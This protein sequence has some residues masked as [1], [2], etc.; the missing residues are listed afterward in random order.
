MK[1]GERIQKIWGEP[2]NTPVFKSDLITGAGRVLVEVK[3]EKYHD[4]DKED[5]KIVAK[6]LFIISKD[7]CITKSI[8]ANLGDRR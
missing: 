7:K 8:C 6:I 2:H 4:R 3:P 1:E 5:I